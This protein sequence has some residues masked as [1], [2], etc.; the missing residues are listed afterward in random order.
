MAPNGGQ[1]G[2]LLPIHFKPEEDELLS[3]WICRLALAHGTDSAALCSSILSPRRRPEEVRMLEVDIRASKEFLSVLA[4][5]TGTS[6][7]RV[8]AMPLAAYEGFLFERWDAPSGERWLINIPRPP[9]ISQQG[10]QYCPLCLAGEAPYYKRSWRLAM[11]TLCTRHRVQLLDRCF[12]CASPVSFLKA[13]YNGM[14][15]P[16]SERMTFCYSCGADLRDA[17]TGRMPPSN[18][19]VAFQERLEKALREGWAERPG[20]GAVPSLLYFPALDRLMRLLAMG[21]MGTKLRRSLGRKYGTG[22]LKITFLT[23]ATHRIPQLNVS[24]RRGLLDLS[25][26]VFGNWPEDFIDICAS[27]NL[28]ARWLWRADET[29]FWFWKVLEEYMYHPRYKPTKEEIESAIRC[30]KKMRRRYR[31][32]PRPYPEEMKIVSQFLSPTTPRQR[33]IQ[34]EFR[35]RG[36]SG[37]KQVR[38]RRMSETLWKKVESVVNSKSKFTK[39]TPAERRNLLDG[40]LYVLHT[41]C[42]WKAM[43]AKFGSYRSAHSMYYHWRRRGMLEEILAL[44]SNL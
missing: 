32:R 39:F 2:K 19:E 36:I 26:R 41:G 20:G 9:R 30:M 28:T 7:Q 18:E 16:P 8:S 29:P 21:E 27:N 44:C 37:E 5:K 33:K 22:L 24:E 40:M 10:L 13:T 43:P 6:T 25:R 38:P 12:R 34:R 31:R 23:K 3:S 14:H 11:I 1:V 17:R 35:A 4:E 42:S 15:A